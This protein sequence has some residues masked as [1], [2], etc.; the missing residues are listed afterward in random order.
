MTHYIICTLVTIHKLEY[1]IT[2]VA[3]HKPK[4]TKDVSEG[5]KENTIVSTRGSYGSPTGVAHR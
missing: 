4:I 5:F 3:L 2:Q 1:I